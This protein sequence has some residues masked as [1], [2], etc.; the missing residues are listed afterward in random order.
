M[1][2]KVWK[3]SESWFV[4]TR[5]LGRLVVVALSVFILTVSL[6]PVLA[7]E[8]EK[9]VGIDNVPAP[10]KKAILK[11]VGAGRLVDIGEFTEGGK[12]VHYE[13]E[14]HVDGQEYD[15]LFAPDGKVLDKIHEG[16]VGAEK[17]K[18]EEAEFFI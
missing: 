11:A 6:I 18:L 16:A 15:V 12:V 17:A 14:M 7:Q 1:N 9:K 4:V 5:P 3:S 10:V 2:T 13:I 8:G